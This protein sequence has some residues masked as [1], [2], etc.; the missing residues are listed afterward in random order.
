MKQTTTYYM[1]TI[2]DKPGTFA[3]GMVCFAGGSATLAKNLR[4]IRREQVASRASDAECQTSKV[5]EYGYIRV[6]VPC[7]E[8]E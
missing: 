4:Q 3:G 7:G 5:W 8:G 6:R 2:E 1:H